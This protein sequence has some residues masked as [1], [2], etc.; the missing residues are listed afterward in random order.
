MK[1]TVRLTDLEIKI[2]KIL[3]ECDQNL[4]IQDIA[5]HLKDEGISVQSVTQSVR[6]LVNKKAIAVNDLVPVERVYARA[7]GPCFSKEEYLAE[8]YERLQK[9]IFGANKVNLTGIAV[10][11]L[12]NQK[13]GDI[14]MNEIEELQMI[15]EEKKNQLKKE[16]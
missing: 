2:M 15:I 7:F 12:N 16:M 3:W 4:T 10:A 8:E 13:S 14:G 1:K 6:H 9:L 5:L 11:L